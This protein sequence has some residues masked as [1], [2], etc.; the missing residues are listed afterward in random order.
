[1]CCVVLC[2]VVL[3]C[4]VLC[5]VVL[6]IAISEGLERPLGGDFGGFRVFTRT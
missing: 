2:C 5:C 6:C 1:M 3:C 4:V